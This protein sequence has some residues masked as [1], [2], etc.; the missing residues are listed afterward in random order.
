MCQGGDYEIGGGRLGALE[1]G[2]ANRPR[3]ADILR[4][5]DEDIDLH[6]V[7]DAHA[8]GGEDGDDVDPALLR[9]RLE[10][11]EDGSIRRGADLT[12]N[13]QP[14]GVCR[15]LHGLAVAAEGFHDGR[16]VQMFEHAVVS[17]LGS[18][19]VLAATQRYLFR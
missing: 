18:A 13:I 5:G 12:G 14:A 9:L 2:V 1:R 15:R 17:R 6:E 10:A 4:A 8:A 16:R 19:V 7:L 11:L 3:G